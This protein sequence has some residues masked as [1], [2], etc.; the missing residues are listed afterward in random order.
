MAVPRARAGRRALAGALLAGATLAAAFVWWA[1]PPQDVPPT[2]PAPPAARYVAPA[3]VHSAATAAAEEADGDAM[4]QV[5]IPPGSAGNDPFTAALAAART[6]PPPVPPQAI[7][8]AKSFEEAIAAMRAARGEAPPAAAVVSP[9][10][11]R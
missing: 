7:V 8:Q 4:P 3:L 2:A 6:V 5:R 1:G 10:G 9:F 11:A